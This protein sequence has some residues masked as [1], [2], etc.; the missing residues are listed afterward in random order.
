MSNENSL[1]S[2]LKNIFASLAIVLSFVVAT[3]IYIFIL[4]DP[5]HFDAEGHPLAG[6]YMGMVYKGGFI[7]PI[8]IGINLI[9][10]TFSIERG[11]TV[12]KAKGKG[13]LEPF[14]R[15]I[16]SLLSK[17]ELETAISECDKQK[18]SLANVVRSGLTKYKFLQWTKRLKLLLFKKN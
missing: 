6:D 11:I 12:A 18:G 9:I 5:S 7:V 17:N 2:N 8:L 1:G 4:G 14:V 16:K 13:R 15:K 10:I 3:M